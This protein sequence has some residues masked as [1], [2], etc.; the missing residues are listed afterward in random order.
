MQGAAERGMLI[1]FHS[2]VNK[3]IFNTGLMVWIDGVKEFS[4]LIN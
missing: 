2:H 1:L 4:W 3:F